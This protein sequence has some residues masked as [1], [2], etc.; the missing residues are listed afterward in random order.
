MNGRMNNPMP[1]SQ[2]DIEDEAALYSL[3][4]LDP[5]SRFEE[6]LESDSAAV[7]ALSRYDS[8]AALLAESL[9]PIAPPERIKQRLFKTIGPAVENGFGAM[10]SNEGKW[11]RSD[12]PGVTY[13]KLYFDRPSGLITMLV[14]MEPG[15]I[16][17]AHRH[18]HTEQCLVLEGDLIHDGHI[19]HPGDFTWAT[20]GSIDPTL[21]TEKGNLLLIISDEKEERV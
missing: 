3:G 2:E 12:V 16:Y 1:E 20:A 21:G 8:P 5:H 7:A 6:L 17:P 18:S 14:R 19:Y 13:K 9:E 10:R 15:T 11:K 4:A